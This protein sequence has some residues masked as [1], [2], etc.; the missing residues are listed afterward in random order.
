MRCRVCWKA[1]Q[2]GSRSAS[3][4][5][6]LSSRGGYGRATVANDQNK[7][8]PDD[9]LRGLRRASIKAFIA[10]SIFLVVIDAL[11]RLFRDASFHVDAVVAG[12]VF[13][14]LLSL[15]GLEGIQKLLSK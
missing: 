2:L 6:R 9:D 14:T 4:S 11:G 3:S 1:S 13:G 8:K 10:L 12:L 7:P 15:L 5:G